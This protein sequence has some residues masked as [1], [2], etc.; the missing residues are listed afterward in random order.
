VE[1]ERWRQIERLYYSAL[2][3][4]A[5]RRAAFLDQACAGDRNL[6][7]EVESLLAPLEGDETYLEAPAL[8]VA[9][10]ALAREQIRRSSPGRMVSHYRILSRL[11]GGGMGDVYKAEDT[12]LGRLVALKFLRGGPVS[13]PQTIERFFREARNASALNHPNICSIYAIDEFEGEPF[14]TM[15]LLEGQTLRDRISAGP[16][17]IDELLDFAVQIAD[18]LDAAHSRTIV[19]RDL[20][21]ANL[22][23]T[24]GNWVKLLDF[25]L[26]KL[27]PA[28]SIDSGGLT[29]SGVAIGTVAYMS[30]EQARAEPLDARTDLFSFGAVLYEMA[31][32][33][34]AFDG[35]S[36]AVIF[37]AILSQAPTPVSKLRPDLPPEFE[38]II[39]KALEKD[40]DQRYQH[41]ADL[42]A[43]L[44]RLKMDRDSR[45]HTRSGQSAMRRDPALEWPARHCFLSRV[46]SRRQADRF[47]LGWIPTQGLPHL[48]AAGCAE[49]RRAV[50]AHPPA[51]FRPQSRL[52]AGR[53]PDRLHSRF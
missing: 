36:V 13:D 18:G 14:I 20:K 25:G 34:P 51:G 32:G 44:K 29:N 52:V 43:D 2:E 39:G 4:E 48:C 30:P 10:K 22:F 5:D 38:Q 15:E 42:R 41:A 11:G 26:A 40:R 7:R 6:R 12:K 9:A 33:R 31:T 49:W 16:L 27:L 21:P 3:L 24:T 53:R 47:Q 46:A 8:Q 35:A 50:A 45:Q 1:P 17:S 37:H 19:H 28:A 23:I